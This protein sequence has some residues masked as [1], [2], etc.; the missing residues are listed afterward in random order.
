L[1]KVR[2]LEE[3]V[4]ELAKLP[5]IGR[6]TA[7]RL[8]IH[9]LK[10]KEAD[11]ERLANRIST[12]RKDIKICKN[13]G[14]MSETEL[15]PI[16]SDP[17]RDKSFICVVEDAKDL[18]VIEQVGYFKGVYHVL[19]GKISPLD[20]IGPDDLRIKELVDKV[21]NRDVR[22]VILA[23]NSD[24]DGETTAVYVAN[25]LRQYGV[26]VTKLAS[27]IPLGT[28]IEYAD[29]LTVLRAIEGRHKA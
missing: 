22:E 28:H 9:M 12:F 3:L 6:K 18:F 26:S 24:I 11:V 7:S 27:G 16:C 5:G 25:L 8:S 15:C 17:K 4:T 21:S 14:G 10:M 29:E 20:G 2:L 23:T 1:Y 13:C 19:G